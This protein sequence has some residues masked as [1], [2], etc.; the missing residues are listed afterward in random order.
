MN[1]LRDENIRLKML[2][3]E[4]SPN[5]NSFSELSDIRN[6]SPNKSLDKIIKSMNNSETSDKES[7]RLIKRI[8][9]CKSINNDIISQSF[10]D[11][12]GKRVVVSIY[13]GDQKLK[14]DDIL[15]V[16][17]KFKCIFFI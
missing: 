16:I 11:G 7:D 3:N 2:V 17:I 5:N 12:E 6:K 14:F 1:S 4:N 15:M 10:K 9:E 8:E 13:C